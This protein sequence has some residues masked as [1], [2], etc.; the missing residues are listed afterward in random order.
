MSQTDLASPQVDFSNDLVNLTVHRKPACRVE[1]HVKTGEKLISQARKMAIKAINKEVSFPG[2]RPGKAPE[3]VILKKYPNDIDKQLH[4][5]LADLVYVEAQK[6]ARIPL[7][8]NNAQISFDMKS[9]TATQAELLF[10]FETEPVI[11]QIDKTLFK[12]QAV[13]RLEVGETQI[14]EAV[15]QMLFFFAEW[16][17][18]EDRPTQ[19]GDYVMIDLDT[20]DG[21]HV[22]RVFNHIR[23]EVSPERMANWM[24]SLV[25]GSKT[26]DVL[27]GMSEPDDDA[28]EAD[29]NEFKPKKVRVTVLKVEEASLPAIDDEFAKKVGAVDVAQMYKT[30]S[31]LLNKQAEEK[32]SGQLREQINTFLSTQYPF[33]LPLS[34]VE[35]EKKQ[36]LSEMMQDPK[37]KTAWQKMSQEERKTQEQALADEA[38]QAVRL[39]YLSRQIVRD[40]N[41]PVTHKEVQYE[42]VA[43]LQSNGTRDVEVDRI[44]REVYA[45]AFSKVILAKAQDFILEE[46]A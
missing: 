26:G 7:L 37:A 40:A 24:R 2:F 36:R 29:R 21:E 19:A 8:N 41:V 15:K 17:L 10:S 27:E 32:V 13:N 11:P 43:L 6:L 39:F 44:P 18:V 46:K 4:K 34:L 12:P 25:I 23:F 38:A 42:A 9:K 30:V 3:E 16:K 45:L 20:I 1:F 28:S 22:E 33:D 5:S 14:N 31:D 35:A